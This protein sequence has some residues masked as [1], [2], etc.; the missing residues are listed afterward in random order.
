M[1]TNIILRIVI[2]LAHYADHDGTHSA[3]L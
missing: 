2:H 1:V 3:T